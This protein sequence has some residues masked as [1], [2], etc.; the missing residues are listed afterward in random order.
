MK[1]SHNIRY[2]NTLYIYKVDEMSMKWLGCLNHNLHLQHES[3]KPREFP[4]TTTVLCM[5][6]VAVASL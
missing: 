3:Q 4:T 2:R 5:Y 1:T 6:Q